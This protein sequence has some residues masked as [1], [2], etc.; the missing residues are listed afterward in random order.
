MIAGINFQPGSQDGDQQRRPQRPNGSMEGVQEA[1]KVLSL[2]LPK[3]VGAQA[4][5]PS[6]L[7]QSQGSGG[8]HS[9]DSMVERVLQRIFPTASR[10]PGAPNAPMVPPPVGADREAQGAP[11][12]PTSD[13][14][15]PDLFRPSSTPRVIADLPMAPLVG[16]APRWPNQPTWDGGG[17]PSPSMI[18]ELLPAW[19]QPQI[20][21]GNGPSPLP[22]LRRQLDWLPSS[23][24]P[25]RNELI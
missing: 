25:E 19:E 6:A 8:N 23:P 14:R 4:V 22:D 12:S 24:S 11:T 18:G 13:T 3:V 16:F 17:G 5:A 10:A 7:L 2:H 9:V 15:A 20:G 21:P 1:I